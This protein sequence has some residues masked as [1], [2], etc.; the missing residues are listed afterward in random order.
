MKV[1]FKSTLL[2]ASLSVLLF[3]CG[4]GGSDTTNPPVTPPP[5]GS[6]ATGNVSSNTPG[7]Q[8]VAAATGA[9]LT[10]PEGAVPRTAAGDVGTIAFSVE[11]EAAASVTAPAAFSPR[12]R[13]IS[14]WTWRHGVQQASGGDPAGNR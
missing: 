6:S 13:R 11:K 7:V 2:A 3:G 5:P 12:G 9:T 10:I 1:P 14:V 8:S 4:G